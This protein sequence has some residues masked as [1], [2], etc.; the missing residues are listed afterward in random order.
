MAPERD[1]AEKLAAE[2]AMFHRE[3]ELA[4]G[5]AALKTSRAARIAQ[6]PDWDEPPKVIR[7]TALAGKLRQRGTIRDLFIMKEILDAPVALR[8]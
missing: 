2:A 5:E 7:A 8:K 3:K 6:S 4:D 1:Q